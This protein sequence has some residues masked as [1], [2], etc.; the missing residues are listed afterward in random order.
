MS[1]QCTMYDKESGMH[2]R[3]KAGF[4][5]V[6]LCSGGP[7]GKNLGRCRSCGQPRKSI[8]TDSLTPDCMK[9][10]LPDW[11]MPKEPCQ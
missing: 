1:D 7:S 4:I 8:Y 5:Q 2:G 9:D 6:P 10:D 3:C 11:R